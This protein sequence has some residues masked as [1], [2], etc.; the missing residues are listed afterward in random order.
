MTITHSDIDWSVRPKPPKRDTA[1]NDNQESSPQE[2]QKFTTGVE[3]DQE[4][5]EE[6]PEP[7]VNIISA[8]WCDTLNNPALHENDKLSDSLNDQNK[9]IYLFIEV[10]KEKQNL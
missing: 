5:E 3:S 6:E 1:K 2:E 9:K 7:E 8:E 4:C 10:T